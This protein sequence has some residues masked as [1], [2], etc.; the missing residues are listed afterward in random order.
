MLK[1]QLK[2]KKMRDQNEKN[3]GDQNKLPIHIRKKSTWKDQI[4]KKILDGKKKTSLGHAN[5]LLDVSK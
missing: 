5:Q 3:L 2:R 1:D 4:R